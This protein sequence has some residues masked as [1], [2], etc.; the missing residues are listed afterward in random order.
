M[1]DASDTPVRAPIVAVAATCDLGVLITKRRD[2]VPPWGFL[3]GKIELGE[4][5]ADAAEREAIEEAGLYIRAGETI[6]ERI[7]PVT[8]TLTYYMQA[9]PVHGTDVSV[10]D[11]AELEWVGWLPLAEAA[12][13]MAAFGG[14]YPPVYDYLADLLSA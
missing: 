14:M 10:H 8:K 12:E 9:T 2:G 13:R 4:S 3:T 11:A 1:P 5:P 7:H 6:A